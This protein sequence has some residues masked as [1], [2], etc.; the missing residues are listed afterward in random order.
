[1]LIGLIWQNKL[2]SSLMSTI[3]MNMLTELM[4]KRATLLRFIMIS[5][6]ETLLRTGIF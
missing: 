1:M 5:Q 4:I 3:T 2:T 6:M